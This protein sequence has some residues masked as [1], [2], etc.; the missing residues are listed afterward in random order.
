VAVVF[1]AVTLS[2]AGRQ[3]QHRI[4][5]IQGLDRSLLI[6]AKCRCMLRRPEVQTDN[7]SRLLLKGG[8]V[9]S[10]IAIQAMR[11][12]TQLRPNPLHG[13]LAHP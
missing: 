9:G 13:V 5:P 8:I 4:Q 7:V 3:R 10:H 2:P 11:L 12:Q 6:H 1:E